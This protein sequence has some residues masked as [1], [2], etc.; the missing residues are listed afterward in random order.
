M[1]RWQVV[2]EKHMAIDDKRFTNLALQ[3]NKWLVSWQLISVEK[4]A[5]QTVQNN[6]KQHNK[7]KIWL[8][9]QLASWCN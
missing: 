4:Q 7:L 9:Y 5:L 6:I 2:I 8:K 1:L 3:K